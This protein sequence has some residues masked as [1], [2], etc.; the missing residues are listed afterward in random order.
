M[1]LNMDSSEKEINELAEIRDLLR[2]S[3]SALGFLLDEPDLYSVDDV[4]KP[5]DR[6][7]CPCQ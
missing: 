1:I 4:K 2:L 3:E 7:P 6:K 5:W